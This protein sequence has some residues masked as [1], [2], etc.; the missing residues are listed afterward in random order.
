MLKKL[1]IQAANAALIALLVFGNADARAFVAATGWLMCVLFFI[2][3]F[4]S[5][6]RAEA[7]KMLGNRVLGWAVL[8]AFTAGFIYAGYPVLAAFYAFTLA[9]HKFRATDIADKA[10]SNE[11]N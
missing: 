5:M 8:V 10:Q 11:S 1:T 3:W 4:I 2:G 6:N 9:V 7:D